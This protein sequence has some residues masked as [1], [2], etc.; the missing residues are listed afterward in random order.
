M[1]YQLRHTPIFYQ[2]ISFPLTFNFCNIPRLSFVW[3]I[4]L[5][6]FLN[7]NHCFPLLLVKDSGYSFNAY[8][9]QNF[10]QIYVFYLNC[11]NKKTES[12]KMLM[13]EVPESNGG[14]LVPLAYNTKNNSVFCTPGRIWTPTE[15]SV[16]S[17][18][19]HYT[20]RAVLR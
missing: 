19:I 11:Q 6:F 4:F 13:A 14:Y 3:Y 7:F 18:A 9:H 5:S 10:L 20:T 17:S 8:I 1:R 15:T 2:A 12:S 16:V